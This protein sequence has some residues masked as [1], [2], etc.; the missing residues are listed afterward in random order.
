M[1]RFAR[2][3]AT[4]LL[5]TLLSVPLA[6]QVVREQPTG[7]ALEQGLWW[8]YHLKYEEARQ[9]FERYTAQNPK[10]P[11]G[12]FYKTA[13][14]WWQLA[15]QFDKK[16]PE[17]EKRLEA[18]FQD[19]VRVAEALEEST[20][21]KKI[22]ALAHLYGGG[23]EGLK[24]RWL[25]TQ[26]RYVKAYFLGKSGNKQLK[27]ALEYDPELYDAYLGLGIY[28]YYTDTLPGIK[29]VLA[30][31]FIHGDKKRG[32]KEIHL[33]IEKGQHAPV[34]AMM[35]LIEIYTWQERTPERALSYAQ[36]LHHEF[37]HSPAMH[38]AEIIEYYELHQWERLREE[39]QIYLEKSSKQVPYY[40]KEGVFPAHYCLGIAALWGN[41]DTDTAFQH[42]QEIVK[43]D[44]PDSRWVSFAYLR[45][46]Q[47]YDTRGERKQ[48]VDY[49]QKVLSRR[50]F[51][52]THNEARNGLKSPFHF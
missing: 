18:D 33:A 21:D 47:I 25:V 6:A 17:I 46:A 8:L 7:T 2:F 11:A 38:L 9:L 36:Q 28:D 31:L 49:Y 52:G 12:Y 13:A 42:M 39:S 3:P 51:W 29:K 32:L 50:N 16:L 24:G 27:Q 14:D 20:K 22:K 5:F 23:A 1:R 44:E 43:G 4:F 35:F 48:A 37:P 15:Q 34:E 30:N 19:T 40:P 26:G 10:D 45:L 41:H